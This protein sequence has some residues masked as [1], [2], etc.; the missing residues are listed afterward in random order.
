MATAHLAFDHKG[1]REKGFFGTAVMAKV[2]GNDWD[3]KRLLMYTANRQTFRI[4]AGFRT[5]FASVP[6]VLAWLVPRIGDSVLPAILH[7]FLWRILVPLG[8]LG[9]VCADGIFRQALRLEGVPFVLRWLCW[10]AVRWGALTRPGG[11]RGWS[12]TAPHVLFWTVVALP[13]LLPAVVTVTAALLLLQLSELA[14]W[15]F[16]KLSRSDKRLNAPVIPPTT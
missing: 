1:T 6:R 9:H 15:P 5:D 7:D 11:W 3:M 8:Y 10:T 12:E 4:P 13:L 14:A 16:L 2:G